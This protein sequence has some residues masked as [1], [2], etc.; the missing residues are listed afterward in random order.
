MNG[1]QYGPHTLT[2]IH[3]LTKGIGYD[4][5]VGKDDRRI[6]RKPLHRL[7]RYLRGKIGIVAKIQKGAGAGPHFLV[8]RQITSGLAHEP[9][10]RTIHLLAPK[11]T[12]Q[13]V[14]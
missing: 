10:G 11:R 1:F 9:Y 2:K 13:P 4:Q 7:Q 6:E 3:P 8:L 12:D 5:Y 14:G